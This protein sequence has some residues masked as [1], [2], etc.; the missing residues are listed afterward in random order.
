[1]NPTRTVKLNRTQLKAAVA[2]QHS[3]GW[4]SQMGSS[5]LDRP[6]TR[7]KHLEGDGLEAAVMVLIY[8]SDSA[9]ELRSV[10]TRRKDD[11]QHHPG[12]ISLP[13]GRCEE[14]ETI[15]QTALREVEEEIGVERGEIEVLGELDSV[16]I[17]PSD[18]TVTPVVGWCSKEP[19]F[20]VQPE[21]VAELIPVSLE[22]LLNPA[23]RKISS[24]AS[25]AKDRDVPWFSINGH[26]VWGATAIILDDF[27]R[28][29]QLVLD[30]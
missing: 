4:V 1:M 20:A 23:I 16:Y 8:E 14:D 22:Q 13:G 5:K 7:P 17:P 12:Q 6:Q 2:R 19:T 26:Q 27:S 29:L 11:L 10:L 21:E 30:D 18:F 25:D 24:V 28:R 3:D 9:P 15:E